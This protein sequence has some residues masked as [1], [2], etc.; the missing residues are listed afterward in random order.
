MNTL[1][2]T[3]RQ[4]YFIWML[5][6]CACAR[7]CN[8]VCCRNGWSDPEEPSLRTHT[9]TEESLRSASSVFSLRTPSVRGGV[10]RR[11]RGQAPPG[12]RPKATRSLARSLTSQQ[13][14]FPLIAHTENLRRL[15][16]GSPCG[17]NMIYSLFIYCCCFI[18][19]RSVDITVQ[20]K[21]TS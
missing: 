9:D 6:V 2:R 14:V 15:A 3:H 8:C 11:N 20:R 13:S 10:E 16:E 18:E 12:T 17:V 7:V 19:K 21:Q 1:V 5:S 4:C